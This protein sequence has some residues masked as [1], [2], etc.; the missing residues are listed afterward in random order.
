MYSSQSEGEATDATVKSKNRRGKTEAVPQLIDALSV[1][2]IGTLLLR[3]PTTV[4]DLYR[5]AASGDLVYYRAITTL[6]VSM[7]QRLP[8]NYNLYLDPQ[9]TLKPSSLHRAV[10]ENISAFKQS[11]GMLTPPINHVLVLYRWVSYLALPLEV[12]SAVLRIAKMLEIDF[13]YHRL[14]TSKPTPKIVVLRYAEGILMALLVMATKLLFPWDG[15][16]RYPRKPTEFSALSMDWSAWSTAREKYDQAV[17][18][19]Q[20]LGYEDALRVSEHDV[21]GMSDE[22]LDEY[23]DWYGSTFTSETVREIG[24]AGKEAEFRRAMFRFFPIDRPAEQS[25]ETGQTRSPSPSA[26]H[27]GD[28]IKDVQTALR[29]IRVKQDDDTS[30]GTGVIQRPGSNYKRYREAS[31]LSGHA[32]MFYKEAAKL[33]GLSLGLLVRGVFGLEKRLEEWEVKARKQDVDPDVQQL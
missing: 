19:R 15:I 28:R 3:L 33:S 6:A 30:A 29:P 1:C 16:R 20:R 5:W 8:F 23:M 18:N 27:Q 9:N 10:L 22:K 21:L 25:A 7:K 32:D 13:D 4:N 11:F 26:D 14:E 17:K 12:Y 31:E 24:R 2:Y